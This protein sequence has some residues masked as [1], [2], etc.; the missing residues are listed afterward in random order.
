M[1]AIHEDLCYYIERTDKSETPQSG[2]KNVK[3]GEIIMKKSIITTI[4][5][6]SVLSLSACGHDLSA[7]GPDFSAP[8]LP[9]SSDASESDSAEL[10]TETEPAIETTTSPELFFS[11]DEIAG[12]WVEE[13]TGNI[14]TVN[15]D[16]SF[17]FKYVEGGTRFGT[18]RIED[19]FYSDGSRKYWYS[20]YENDETLWIRFRCPQKPDQMYTDDEAAMHFLH[21]DS[22]I[23][24]APTIPEAKDL[25]DALA[26]ADRLMSGSGIAADE[27]TEYKTDDG[28][29]Y[30]KSVDVFYTTTDDVRKYLYS[31]MTEQF[32][33]SD[34]DF[35]F[36]TG[37]PKCIDV[38]GELYIE[39]RP[40]G[41]KYSFY[42]EDPTV[43]RTD[44]GYSIIIRNNDYGADNTVVLDVV[45]EDGRWKI[46]AVHT[47]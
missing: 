16:A 45:K 2:V 41:G 11:T 31:Y 29:V 24:F 13:D 35:L 4:A 47:S 3:K 17:T 25:R 15:D 18:V 27:N 9:S 12:E 23:P 5:L 40:V 33:S 14:L 36:G 6:L 37:T 1:L 44:D 34:Y 8:S 22:D 39:Y 7:S 46:N 32:I 19:E 38:D 43:T 21:N 28:T 26:F 42:D 30:H 10:T 20:L